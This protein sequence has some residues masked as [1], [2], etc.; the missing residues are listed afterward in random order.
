MSRI[1]D[2]NKWEKEHNVK[3]KES[4]L[5]GKTNVLHCGDDAYLFIAIQFGNIHIKVCKPVN[6]KR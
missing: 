4:K 1:L 6:L 5:E 2:H 3:F